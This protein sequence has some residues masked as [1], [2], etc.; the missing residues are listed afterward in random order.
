MFYKLSFHRWSYWWTHNPHFFVSVPIPVVNSCLSSTNNYMKYFSR[1]CS[2]IFMIYLFLFYLKC[3]IKLQLSVGVDSLAIFFT[4][5]IVFL[6]LVLR[7]IAFFCVLSC[8]LLFLCLDI[9][10]APLF[11]LNIFPYFLVLP[12]WFIYHFCLSIF[13]CFKSGL[14]YTGC[15][16]LILLFYIVTSSDRKVYFCVWKKMF[17]AIW[18]AYLNSYFLNFQMCFFAL[19][20]RNQLWYLKTFFWSVWLLVY[21]FG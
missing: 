7:N 14:M 16:I 4:G 8:L 12:I 1:L 13:N 6:V 17:T 5:L 10:V 20:L 19:L 15:Y 3:F 2:F 21:F 9:F 11:L 18:R